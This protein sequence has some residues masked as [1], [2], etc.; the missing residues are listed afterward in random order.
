MK[1][2]ETMIGLIHAGALADLER[3]K[4]EVEPPRHRYWAYQPWQARQEDA[5][6]NI[7]PLNASAWLGV[8]RVSDAGTMALSRAYRAGEQGGRWHRVIEN[9]RTVALQLLEVGDE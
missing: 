7:V 1:Q 3:I 8:D 5:K 4:A 9:R 6:N 2:N